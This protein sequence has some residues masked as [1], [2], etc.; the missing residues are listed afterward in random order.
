MKK[1][2]LSS[3]NSRNPLVGVGFEDRKKRERGFPINDTKTTGSFDL[4]LKYIVCNNTYV[5][6]NIYIYINIILQK[7]SYIYMSHCGISYTTLIDWLV[8]GHM[9]KVT[10]QKG[11]KTCCRPFYEFGQSK[12]TIF[13]QSAQNPLQISRIHQVFYF[14]FLFFYLNWFKTLQNLFDHYYPLFCVEFI[15]WKYFQS[16]ATSRREWHK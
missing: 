2:Q 4:D 10:C 5:Y 13:Q 12:N 3:E 8:E 15:L 11:Y 9:N 1:Q 16:A 14:L 6:K 7:A